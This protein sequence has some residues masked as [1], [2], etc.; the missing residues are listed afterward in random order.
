M[1]TGACLN[2]AWHLGLFGRELLG[3]SATPTKPQTKALPN[4][5]TYNEAPNKSSP[6]LANSS[7]FKQQH[8]LVLS[9]RRSTVTF[10]RVVSMISMVQTSPT[11]IPLS[12]QKLFQPPT[13]WPQFWYRFRHACQDLVLLVEVLSVIMQQQQQQQQHSIFSQASW[14]RLGMKPERNKFKIQAH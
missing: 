2:L 4:W 9:S 1:D 10:H 14:G 3:V 5:P 12:R 13:S 8:Y 6:K 11:L 7:A